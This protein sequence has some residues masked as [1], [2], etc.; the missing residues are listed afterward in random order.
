MNILE[1]IPQRPPFVMID[2]ITEV[3]GDNTSTSFEI[4]SDNLF[5]EDGAFYEGG[6]IENIA[7]TIAAGAGYR[8]KQN[9]G[10]PKMGVIASIRKLKIMQRPKVGQTIHTK[11]ELITNFETALVVKGT[12]TCNGENIANCQMNVFIIDQPEMLK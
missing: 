8:L 1:Y 2:K 7:Q 4:T 6:L 11:A 10:E 12:V 5:T 3:E 9:G